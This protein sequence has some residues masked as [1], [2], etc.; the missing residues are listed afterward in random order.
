M[1][2]ETLGKVI[3][4]S[5][6][7]HKGQKYGHKDYFK[8]HITPVSEKAVDIA[9]A[10]N[11]IVTNWDEAID[12]NLVSA[13]A[14]LH[15]AVEDKISMGQLMD[16]LSEIIDDYDEYYDVAWAVENLTRGE[17]V[18]YYEYIDSINGR[19]PLIVKL[20]DLDINIGNSNKKFKKFD[21]YLFAK[22]FISS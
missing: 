3:A 5:K 9:N 8:A 10:L 4:Y 11:L 7:I 18:G 13:V 15:D 6:K 22:F 1:D 21:L 14:H 2:N 20:A 12:I 16:D 19:L 17:D